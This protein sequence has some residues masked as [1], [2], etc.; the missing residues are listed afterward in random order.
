[1]PPLITSFVVKVPLR[2]TYVTL[3]VGECKITR[4]VAPVTEPVIISPTVNVPVAF[5]SVSVG[6]TGAVP[7]AADSYTA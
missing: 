2:T 5:D 1:M 3:V 6:V 4:P 7:N